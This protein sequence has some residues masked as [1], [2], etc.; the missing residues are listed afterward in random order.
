MEAGAP[1]E[2]QMKWGV[3]FHYFKNRIFVLSAKSVGF[4]EKNKILNNR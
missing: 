2:P 4:L 3:G 1:N